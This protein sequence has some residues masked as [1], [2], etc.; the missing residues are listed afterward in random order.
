MGWVVLL[1]PVALTAGCGD[2]GTDPPAWCVSDHALPL[3]ERTVTWHGGAKQV[4]TQRCVRCHT[5]GSI[6]PF[7][8]GAYGNARDLAEAIRSA[9]LSRHMPPWP[10][11]ACCG[12]G[13]RSDFSLS[14]QEAS[15]LVAWVNAGAPEGDPTPD[16]APS[17][18]R[19]LPRVDAQI[20][21]PQAYFPK[22]VEGTAD[23]TRCFLLPW[24]ERETVYVTGLDVKPAAL[25]QVHHV[26]ALVAAPTDVDS[27]KSQ[28][29]AD[30]GPGFSCPGGLVWPYSDF[31]GGWSPG[32]EPTV[33]PE[34]LGHEVKKGSKILLTVHYSLPVQGQLVEDRTTLELM[35]QKEKTRK[36]ESLPVYN[37]RWVW[38]GMPI[39]KD[40][41]NVTHAF[42]YAP[43]DLTALRYELFSVNLHMHERGTRGRVVIL[44]EN[45]DTE[46]LI[47]V[48]R[49]DHRWQ[50]D[51]TFNAPVLL[52]RN[53]ELFVECVFDNTAEHQRVVFGRRE[54]SKDRNWGEQDEMCVAFVGAAALPWYSPDPR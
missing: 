26:L 5:E 44:R 53:D 49:Y 54:E 13:Y 41:N 24:P 33:L 4:V 16:T 40:T 29:D 2:N 10:P 28:D 17:M 7:D 46:C 25:Q 6:G 22:P 35:F 47:Q 43:S 18:P 38:G 15:T 30:D 19:A 9:V 45:G 32:W 42:R 8:L 14:P 50:G 34:G 11:E 27:L 20:T 39:P 37:T 3:E 21:M 51:Y 12:K 48:D 1:L 31:L 52:N 36:M 23:D